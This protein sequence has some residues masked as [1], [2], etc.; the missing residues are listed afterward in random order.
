MAE[1]WQKKLTNKRNHVLKMKATLS[2]NSEA[3]LSKENNKYDQ[4]LQQAEELVTSWL[5][6][7]NKELLEKLLTLC[8][9]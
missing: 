4:V 2:A 6:E 3:I 1:S 7:S 8:E 5:S 9:A